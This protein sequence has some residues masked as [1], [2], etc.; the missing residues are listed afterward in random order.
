VQLL[1]PLQD[2]GR[3]R[4][5]P[6]LGQVLAQVDQGRRRLPQRLRP[7]GELFEGGP[8]LAHHR[9][10]QLLPPRVGVRLAEDDQQALAP[11][12]VAARLHEDPVVQ[13]GD[14]LIADGRAGDP[15]RDRVGR[16]RPRQAVIDERRRVGTVRLGVLEFARGE[17]SQLEHAFEPV[18]HVQVG[19]DLLQ[20]LPHVLGNAPDQAL[21][22]T[23]EGGARGGPLA[24]LHQP[25]DFFQGGLHG[26]L[27]LRGPLGGLRGPQVPLV[28]EPDGPDQVRDEEQGQGGHPRR[29]P[30]PPA[31]QVG[32]QRLA[33]GRDRLA[34]QPLFHVVGQVARGGVA[35]VRV[36]GHGLQDD[37]LQAGRD[38]S[39][40]LPRRR[41]LATLHPGQD[42][43]VIVPGEG[44][45]AG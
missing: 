9:V 10:A 25:V 4:P 17:R 11:L 34:G 12:G 26:L 32:P 8:V 41:K 39:P 2:P 38:L 30:P 18:H 6:G 24:L 27:L 37:R 36:Q 40:D 7:A 5:G 28:L 22:G 21:L 31:G 33:V 42:V 23:R 3:R 43:P 45:P 19:A 1:G 29:V 16:R 20:P 14:Q 15:F 13:G 44:R 35:V